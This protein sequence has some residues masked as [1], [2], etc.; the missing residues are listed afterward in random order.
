MPKNNILLV[1][2]NHLYDNLFK[3]YRK[4]FLMNHLVGSIKNI[5]DEDI[6]KYNVICIVVYHYYDLIE[7]LRL[8]NMSSPIIVATS[9]TTILNKLKRYNYDYIIDLNKLN[10]IT[11]LGDCF[12][13]IEGKS[14]N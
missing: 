2:K 7:I 5:L 3:G 4:S 1:D 8:H 14:N 12:S 10:Y 11:D 13:K 6:L 9:N